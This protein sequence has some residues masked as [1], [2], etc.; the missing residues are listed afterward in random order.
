MLRNFKIYVYMNSRADKL[1][2]KWKRS[3][4]LSTWESFC[5]TRV[6]GNDGCGWIYDGVV[7]WLGRR[8]NGDTIEW[9][10][11]WSRL[12]WS[13]YNSGWWESDSPGRVACCGGA[14]SMLQFWLETG[15]VEM[16][17]CRKMKRRQRSHLGSMRRKRDM[18]WWY[19]N[20]GRRRGGTG[21]GK[22]RRQ[23]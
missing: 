6:K 16:K 12:R 20:I 15:G 14:D 18:M 21:E 13:F 4:S 1:L 10:E 2:G 9:C 19:D 5:G 23:C 8:Q 7:L 17:H 22:G 11:E 3:T